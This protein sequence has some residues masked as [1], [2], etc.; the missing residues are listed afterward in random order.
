M[1]IV[2]MGTPDFA[3][4]SLKAMIESSHEVVG[5]VTQPDRPQGR[6]LKMRPPP[7]K[8]LAETHAM[9]VLQPERLGARSFRE[10]LRGLE[11]DLFVVVAFRILPASVL[12]IPACGAVNLHASL[13]PKYRG[14]APIQ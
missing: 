4:P 14:A 10:V 7:V 13:L 2:F 6:G 3:I 1:K 9:P 11:G 12:S 5:V 8:D